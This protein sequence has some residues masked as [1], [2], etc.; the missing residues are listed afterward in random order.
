MN[1]RVREDITKLTEGIRGSWG[2]GTPHTFQGCHVF[3]A[4]LTDSMIAKMLKNI[5]L[6]R[7]IIF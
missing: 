4:I 5:F 2:R 1:V 3:I 6:L 7:E